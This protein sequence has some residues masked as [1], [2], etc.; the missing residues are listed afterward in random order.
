MSLTVVNSQNANGQPLNQPVTISISA[1]HSVGCVWYFDDGGG[2]GTVTSITDSAGNT[3]ALG[4]SAVDA[5]GNH[6]VGTGYFLAIA[7][8]ITT[9]TAHVTGGTGNFVG[10]TVW[11]ITA[12]GTIS[13]AGTAALDTPSTSTATDSLH[14]GALNLTDSTDGLIFGM[15]FDL[16]SNSIAIGTGFTADTTGQNS[17]PG[18]HKAIAVSAANGCTWT[19]GTAGS[20]EL[21]AGLGF[22]VSASGPT[23][24]A[25]IAWVT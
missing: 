25:T 3:Y 19:P 15:A 1:G 24:N 13:I 5:G 7:T 17:S 20:H 4:N 2:G 10:L 14:T 11:D 9:V 23:N 16:S 8:G 18:E 6:H 12:T 22:Q 21:A